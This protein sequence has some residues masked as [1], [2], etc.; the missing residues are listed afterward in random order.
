MFDALMAAVIFQ[1][2][3]KGVTIKKPFNPLQHVDVYSFERRILDCFFLLFVDNILSS[4]SF[5]FVTC[6]H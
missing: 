5:I 3:C 4:M 2:K 6:I 1:S